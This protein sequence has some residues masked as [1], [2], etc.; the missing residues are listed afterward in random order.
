[1]VGQAMQLFYQAPFPALHYTGHQKARGAAAGQGAAARGFERG[2]RTRRTRGA[3]KAPRLAPRGGP[4]ARGPRQ[5]ARAAQASGAAD[6][7]PPGGPN[8]ARTAQSAEPGGAGRTRSEPERD[9]ST[10]STYPPQSAG[11]R[12]GWSD[13]TKSPFCKAAGRRSP[14]KPGK[15]DGGRLIGGADYTKRRFCK[16]RAPV[17][18]QGGGRGALIARQGSADTRSPAAGP[19]KFPG[20]D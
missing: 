19:E 20:R 12:R 11:N 7:A 1:M 18:P 6:R 8:A 9:S 13:Y 4:P 10:E 14:A 5:S 2:T 16:R 17:P 3:I 15:E